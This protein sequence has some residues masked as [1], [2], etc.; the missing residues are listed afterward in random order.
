MARKRQISLVKE[1]HIFGKATE[2][3]TKEFPNSIE[4]QAHAV[5]GVFKSLMKQER[6]KIKKTKR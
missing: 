6:M 3:V 1:A 4:K 5:G 2:I